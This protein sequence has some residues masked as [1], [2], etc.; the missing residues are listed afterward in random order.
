MGGYI[1]IRAPKEK[2]LKERRP[3]C[4][5]VYFPVLNYMK[6]K[7][8]EATN[9]WAI[10]IIDITELGIG[11]ITKEAMQVNDLIA[12]DLLLHKESIPFECLVK[13][14]R[15]SKNEEYFSAGAEFVLLKDIDRR[16]IAQYIKS[17]Y[18]VK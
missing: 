16:Q 3:I 18:I 10:Q 6:I 4:V 9:Q 14:K 7:T 1:M 5:N 11:F 12:F 8:S 13:I 15:I 17:T 2:R